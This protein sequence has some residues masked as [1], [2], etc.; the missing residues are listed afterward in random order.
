MIFTHS[1]T[2]RSSIVKGLNYSNSKWRSRI[3]WWFMAALLFLVPMI[4][5]IG[6][7]VKNQ[8]ASLQPSDIFTFSAILVLTFCVLWFLVW[9]CEYTLHPD[10]LEIR[11]GKLIHQKIYYKDIKDI[12]RS[13]S[14]LSSPAL[15]F[16]RIKISY[17]KSFILISPER[18]DLFIR[19]LKKRC[20]NFRKPA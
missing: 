13:L 1:L 2:G 9:P 19:E 6:M 3:D 8:T 15:S 10:H 5:L 16:R 12:K 4:L 18:R 20:N 11:C 17:A 14:P 7:L